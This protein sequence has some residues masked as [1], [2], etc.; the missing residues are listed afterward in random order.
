MDQTPADTDK[1]LVSFGTDSDNDISTIFSVSFLARY[2]QSSLCRLQ[3]PLTKRI[4]LFID[5]L[6]FTIMPRGTIHKNEITKILV[7][8]PQK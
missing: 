8:Y 3:L 6:T 1:W 4:S 7:V 5:E 2:G